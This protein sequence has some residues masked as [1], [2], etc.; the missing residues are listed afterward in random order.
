M[1]VHN[2]SN[3]KL[4][5]ILQETLEANFAAEE[6]KYPYDISDVFPTPSLVVQAEYKRELEKKIRVLL[7]D[8]DLSSKEV[9]D[10]LLEIAYWLGIT[11]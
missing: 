8:K 1:D 11:D 5:E 2:L 10:G 9:K 7:L 3:H 4:A 6:S